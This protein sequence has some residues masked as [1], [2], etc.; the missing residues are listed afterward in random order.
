MKLKNLVTL[1]EVQLPEG[2]YWKDEFKGLPFEEREERSITGLLLLFQQEKI[3]GEPI[4]L[5]SADDKN[6]ITRRALKK[7]YQWVR[8][9]ALKMALSMD[10]PLDSRVFEVSFRNSEPPALDSEEVI[11]AK[12]LSDEIYYR[13]TINLRIHREIV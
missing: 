10:S 8:Q 5:A 6:W 2:L 7:L 11:D 1:E 12:P 3:G 4:T 9:P 13:V